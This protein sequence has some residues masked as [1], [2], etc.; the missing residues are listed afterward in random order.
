VITWA[1]DPKIKSIQ[2]KTLATVKWSTLEYFAGRPAA[3]LPPGWHAAIVKE[4][5]LREDTGDER[6]EANDDFQAGDAY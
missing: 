5:A 4:I 6:S 1:T 3:L 2:G